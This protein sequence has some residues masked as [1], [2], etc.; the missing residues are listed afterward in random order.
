M[1]TEEIRYKHN[2]YYVFTLPMFVD[3]LLD[4][5][6]VPSN[7]GA[8]AFDN[9]ITSLSSRCTFSKYPAK[10]VNTWRE[11]NFIEKKLIPFPLEIFEGNTLVTSYFTCRICWPYSRSHTKIR[12]DRPPGPN[13]GRAGKAQNGS[14]STFSRW[15][16]LFLHLVDFLHYLYAIGKTTS[17]TWN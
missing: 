4:C 15:S 5:A 9:T 3:N 17:M 14:I 2:W 12:N 11:R 1:M 10:T 16:L 13:W 6:T 7:V 8:S